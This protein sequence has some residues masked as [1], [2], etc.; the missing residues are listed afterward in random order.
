MPFPYLLP[1]TLGDAAE[2]PGAFDKIV[3]HADDAV[4]RLI[5]Q[6]RDKPNIVAL[7]KISGRRA[8]KLEDELWKVY[9]ERWLETSA[10]AQLDALGKLVGQPRM[11]FADTDYRLNLKARIRLNKGSGTIEDLLTIFKLVTPEGTGIEFTPRY[12]AGFRLQLNTSGFNS[13][14]VALLLSFLRAARGGGIY[15]VLHWITG[16]EADTFTF[17]GGA[18]LGFGSASDASIG[19]KLAGISA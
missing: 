11:Y 19:G 1:F 6:Y 2:T 4:S 16:T 14:T 7:V 8:Q 3:D 9:T 12:P 13:S 10:G 15:G 17:S 18:G 5:E